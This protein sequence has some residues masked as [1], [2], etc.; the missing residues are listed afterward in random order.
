MIRHRLSRI[1]LFAAERTC[2]VLPAVSML[3]EVRRLAASHLHPAEAAVTQHPGARFA[4]A[5]VLGSGPEPRRVPGALAVGQHE[6]Q[7][8]G[9]DRDHPFPCQCAGA[10]L[11]PQPRRLR[12]LC[13]APASVVNILLPCDSSGAEQPCML[14]AKP[15]AVFAAL[16]DNAQRS[17]TLR[18]RC[19]GIYIITLNASS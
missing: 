9:G 14:E 2:L 12:P 4:D 11:E 17:E 6:L 10:V 13:A 7:A 8:A 3:Q 18:I 15:V 16:Q 19:D 1:V 5:V